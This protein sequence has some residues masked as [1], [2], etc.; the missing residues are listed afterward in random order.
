MH[1]IEFNN[2]TKEFP[3]S[4]SEMTGTQFRYFSFL[5]MCR[6]SGLISMPKLEVLFIY[7]VLDLVRTSDSE[8][9]VENITEIRKLVKPYF[10]T[11]ND[12][13][14]KSHL[15]V[16]LNFVNNPLPVIE[17]GKLK[18]HGPSAALQNCSY[19]EVFVHG[20]NALIDFSTDRDETYLD[21]LV[22]ALYRPLV[23]GKR[24]KFDSEANE[25]HLELIKKIQPE[26][27]F[28]VFL[29]FA[30]C[31][32]FITTASELNIGGG[33]TIDIAQLFKP[34]PSQGKN[35]GIGPAGIIY[36]I[37][38]SGVFGNAR[39]TAGE[40]VYVVLTRMVQLHEQ[41]LEQKRNAKRNKT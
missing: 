15:I 1:K 41:Y 28:G 21:D 36:S 25:A 27:K 37:A 23:N 20:Q 22:A 10:T 29:F 18:L 5:E 31:H 14:G 12:K 35:K 6:Q 39:E 13:K 2:I 19:E 24:P 33:T 9:V 11:Q 3:E 38:E 34:D 40:N 17:I 7:H 16:D 8:K 26:V 4:I 32:K 30:S